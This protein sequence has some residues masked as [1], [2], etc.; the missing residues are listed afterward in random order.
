MQLTSDAR[1]TDGGG[2]HQS[3]FPPLTPGNFAAVAARGSRMRPRAESLCT[4]Q[5]VWAGHELGLSITA[6]SSAVGAGCVRTQRAGPLGRQ[7]E[8]AGCW[9]AP[10]LRIR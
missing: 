6:S 10:G 4:Q 9:W 2:G 3:L 7:Q 1:S 5:L 8:A